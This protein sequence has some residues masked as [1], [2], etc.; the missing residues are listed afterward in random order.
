MVAA[1]GA[2]PVP[3]RGNQYLT[4]QALRFVAALMVVV[5]HSTFYTSERL[6][7][8]LGIY[9]PGANGVRLFFVISG[10]VMIVSSQRL[11]G[12]AAGWMVFA[13]KR[14]I[15]IVPLYWGVTLIKLG[16]MLTAPA[17]V[18]HAELDWG[19]IARSFLFIPDYNVDG[20]IRPLMG[21]G[22]TLNME[23]FF[24]L[25][26]T[27]ALVLRVRTIS[28]IAPILIGLSLLSL[29]K[30]P[31]W[32]VAAYF[33]CD[34]IVLD[35]LAGMLI[36]RWAQGGGR[37]PSPAGA[38]A[39]VSIGLLYLFVPGLPRFEH[40]LTG[41]VAITLAAAATIAGAVSLEQVIGK[42]LPS[43]TL[44]LGGASYSLYLF[45]PLIAPAS[46]E[47]FMKLGLTGEAFAV[48]AVLGGIAAAIVA[49]IFIYRF[50]EGPVTRQ[51]ESW[52][53]ARGLLDPQRGSGRT[54]FS[55]LTAEPSKVDP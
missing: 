6:N 9:H 40:P 39:L 35:F 27:V 41:S 33:L 8:T 23:M 51:A 34:P 50:L 7:D 20:E 24:Y 45:H 5:L 10:F 53:R 1:E 16:V 48:V 32:P 2:A 15:R 54:E 13:V 12:S 42:R 49:S 30:T 44:Y 47:V 38:W 26:F 21:V 11:V 28:F 37:A 52:A 29:A 4:I 55:A 18:L 17:V 46:P 3:K 25:L 31:D 14:I 22:W 36:A 43:W 19:Y